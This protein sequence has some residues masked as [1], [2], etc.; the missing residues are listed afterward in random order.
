M[1]LTC[2]E[3]IA[4]SHS[5]GVISSLLS[6]CFHELDGTRRG[7]LSTI[8]RSRQIPVGHQISH[9]LLT[10]IVTLSVSQLNGT[11]YGMWI[12]GLGSK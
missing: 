9:A 12:V 8:L 10:L 7:V 4:R 6:S 11:L 1:E 2:T 5:I 3:A